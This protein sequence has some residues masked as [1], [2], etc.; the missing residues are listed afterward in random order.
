MRQMARA[1]ITEKDLLH[2]VIK[3]HLEDNDVLFI[4]ADVIDPKRL[5]ESLNAIDPENDHPIKVGI[6]PVVGVR[7]RRLKDCVEILSS[8]PTVSA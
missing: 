3:L 1:V 8:N 2:Y 6:I 4:D 5:A 7:G